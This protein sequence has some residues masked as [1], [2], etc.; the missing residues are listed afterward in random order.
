MQSPLPAHSDAPHPPPSPPPRIP[1]PLRACSKSSILC[2]ICLCLGGKPKLLGRADSIARFVRNGCEVA[3]IVVELHGGGDGTQNIV[4]ERTIYA[5]ESRPSKHKYN[6]ALVSGKEVE[7][8]M[9]EMDIQIAN[10][11]QFLPQDR[12]GAFAKLNDVERLLETERAV[13]GDAAV[14]QHNELSA[15]Y[16]RSVE[17]TGEL[18]TLNQAIVGL[19]ADFERLKA[20]KEH[21]ERME[22]SIREREL[23]EAFFPWRDVFDKSKE[24]VER[25]AE[26]A[27]IKGRLRVEQK[28]AEPLKK[29]W[30]GAIKA[31]S[32][33]GKAH[34]AAL[35]KARSARSATTRLLVKSGESVSA[36][37]AA[38]QAI[39]NVQVAR[40]KADG[41]IEIQRRK[42]DDAQ[43]DCTRRLAT[44][45]ATKAAKEKTAVA[46]SELSDEV[47]VADEA[48]RPMQRELQ[49]LVS[50]RKH[51]V[52]RVAGA[53]A[54]H[55]KRMG[56]IAKLHKKIAAATFA[57]RKA[58]DGRRAELQNDVLGPVIT[59]CKIRSALH[60][61]WLD[62]AVGQNVKVLFIAQVRAIDPIPAPLPT[63][64]TP[65]SH[66][67]P[68][69]ERRRLRRAERV[70]AEE[71]QSV[72]GLEDHEH[73]GRAAV[74]AAQ[75]AARR[76]ECSRRQR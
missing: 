28:R 59:S 48:L 51:A 23:L 39:D 12:V 50:R 29:R 27:R 49:A 72:L 63:V 41:K 55:G 54:V 31:A 53:E 16:A 22:R 36:M 20:D 35:K 61:K 24:H 38:V 19:T 65:P 9:L 68:L 40:R 44:K 30:Q 17:K 66:H 15:M 37:D 26:K 46:F 4:V 2:A 25:K 62:R 3:T 21:F 7:K 5:D 43:K 10:L 42:L 69:K 18:A 57:L 32:Q 11:C 45:Q 33:L 60:A 71:C 14:A 76:L 64:L 75:A 58:A 70:A 74:Y 67:P 34:E 73:R 13:L 52:Q 1:P 6:G 47:A 56:V 8:R